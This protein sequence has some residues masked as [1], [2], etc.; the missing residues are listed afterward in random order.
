MPHAPSPQQRA[1]YQWVRTGSGNALI[2]AVA[3]SGKTTTLLNAASMMDGYVSLA[4]YNKKIAMEITAKIKKAGLSRNIQAG[5]FHSFGFRNWRRVAPKV[6]VDGKKVKNLMGKAR[7]PDALTEFCNKLVSMAKQHAV[8]V[9]CEV[10]DY[11]VWLELVD[12]YDII[13]LLT[14]DDPHAVQDGVGYAQALLKLSVDQDADYVD[15]DDMIYAPLVH[16]VSVWQSDWLL[17]DEAQDTNPARLALAKRMLRPGGRAIFVGDPQQAIYGFA[18]ARNDSLDTI[19][20]DFNCTELPLTVTYRCPKSVVQLARTWVRHITAHDSAPEGTVAHLTGAQFD[21]LPAEQ[22]TTDAAMLCRNTAPLVD[23][24]YRLIRR[25]IACHVEGKAIGAGLIKLLSR[26]KTNDLEALYTAMDT[27]R[28][29]ELAKF[30]IKGQEQKAEALSDKIETLRVLAEA[31]PEGSTVSDL[32]Q[33]IRNIFGDTPEDQPAES[34]TLSTVHK[35]K[36]REWKT[37][38][39]LD[40]MALMPSKYARQDWQIEQEYNLIYVAVTRSMDTLIE[41]TRT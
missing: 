19:R 1:V 6:E 11:R 17:V 30:L 27:Y 14:T 36:G 29:R 40:R 39:L 38:Y 2:L 37:V 25:G 15:Y 5:T 3:G 31:L 10:S 8:G 28:Q 16:G 12:H 9:L 18:G 34:F 20:K 4:A 23:T 7:V 41:V 22:F 24:A 21:Q 33:Q 35:S 32:R 13:D 26:W